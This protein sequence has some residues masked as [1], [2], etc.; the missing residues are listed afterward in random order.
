LTGGALVL[1]AGASRRFG[2][3]KRCFDVDGK[4]LL[5]HCLEALAQAGLATRVCVAGG[6]TGLVG[7]L[8]AIDCE[9]IE[10][11]DAA[12]GMGATL[13]QGVAACEDWQQLLVVLADMAWV[14]AD[15]YR[16][17]FAALKESPIVRPSY[18]GSPGQP[19]GFSSRFFP[20]LATLQGDVGGRQLLTQYAQLVHTLPVPDPGVL[21]DLDRPPA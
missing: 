2:S 20:E 13:A 14:Q 8:C 1:A 4:P 10:C 7:D 5:C 18:Q 9:V 21:R 17:L 16:A 3:D 19:V 11:N 15:T 12:L 6:E